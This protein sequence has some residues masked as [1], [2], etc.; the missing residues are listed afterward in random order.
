MCQRIVKSFKSHQEN[1]P[2]N[3][4][5]C[6]KQVIGRHFYSTN[7]F[8]CN[9]IIR[10]SRLTGKFTKVKLILKQA[11]K[12][13]RRSS[14]TYTLSL[15]SALDGSG[16]S[17]PRPGR[18][19]SG[20]ETRYPLYRRLGGTQGRSRRV[21]KILPTTEIRSPNRPARSKSLYPLS[22]PGPQINMLI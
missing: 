18:S 14:G 16:W 2:L 3:A 6:C 10:K 12:A 17:T 15:T 21:G 19:T 9:W 1:K 11:M 7:C 13:Q 20:K 22:Y 5:M 8:I 4:Y